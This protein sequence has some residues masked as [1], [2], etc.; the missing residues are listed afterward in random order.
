MLPEITS[1]SIEG[2]R[3]MKKRKF[4]SPLFRQTKCGWHLECGATSAC[5]LGN[6]NGVRSGG[7]LPA[8]L[9]NRQADADD[10]SMGLPVMQR[11]LAAM[12]Q[13]DRARDREPETEASGFIHVAGIVAA[14]ERL[15]HDILA[16]V[17]NAGAVVLDFDRDV[18]D[19]G[20]RRMV[21]SPPNRT[22]FSTRLVMLR[23][24]SSGRTMA[25]ACSGPALQES[26]SAS[27]ASS[28]SA[29]GG[30]SASGDSSSSF[31]T[32]LIDYKT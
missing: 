29:T 23:C 17:G 1:A 18:V 30:T 25:M 26:L 4:V 3:E 13:H 24:R 6:P 21:A 8:L 27:S 22:A 16:R 32:L 28:Y 2:R 12:R 7:R 20:I 14:H 5:R 31:S 15:E 19:D 9:A 11:Q 10:Q